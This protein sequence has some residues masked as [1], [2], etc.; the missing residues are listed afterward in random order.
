MRKG[1]TLIELILVVALISIITAMSAVFY[2][3][4]LTQNAVL[5]TV[6]Q[7]AGQLHKAQIYAMAGKQNSNW[8]VNYGSQIITLYSGNSYDTRTAAFDEKFTVNSNIS[9]SGL[10]DLNYARVTGLPIPTETTMTISGN[11]NT[12]TITVNSYGVVNR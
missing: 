9:V 12:K 8:G 7:L 11:N 10:T 1:F 3:R 4:F 5:N 2:S 6:D